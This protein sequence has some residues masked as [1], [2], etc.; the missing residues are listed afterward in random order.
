M[1]YPSMQR[2]FTIAKIYKKVNMHC[3]ITGIYLEF[4]SF[5]I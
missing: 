1:F 2:A 5:Y 4:I 3:N